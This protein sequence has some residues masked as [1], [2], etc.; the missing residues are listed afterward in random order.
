MQGILYLDKAPKFAVAVPMA[1]ANAREKTKQKSIRGSEKGTE[2]NFF[3]PFLTINPR[4][5]NKKNIDSIAESRMMGEL[6]SQGKG[7]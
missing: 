3:I 5:N 4:V 6:T 1:A 7:R 2:K